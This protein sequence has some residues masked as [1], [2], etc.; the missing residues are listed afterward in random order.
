M[1]EAAASPKRDILCG[2]PRDKPLS[3]EAVQ[4]LSRPA[5]DDTALAELIR[6]RSAATSD[7]GHKSAGG[8]GGEGGCEECDEGGGGAGGAGGGAVR[9]ASLAAQLGSTL[10]ASEWDEAEL[11]EVTSA[12]RPLTLS[13]QQV[14]ETASETVTVAASSARRRRLVHY[15][16]DSLGLHHVTVAGE[17]R[18]DRAHPGAVQV[19]RRLAATPPAQTSTL[20]PTAQSTP[21]QADQADATVVDCL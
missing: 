19:R 2:W 9:V 16:A 14:G 6:L 21:D 7:G 11:A 15:V 13:S 12:L 3:S 20:C 8:E 5:A 4:T 10:A 18:P 1:H 17:Q